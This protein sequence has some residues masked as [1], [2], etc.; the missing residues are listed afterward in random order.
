[1][2]AS[3]AG[4][5]SAL[6]HRY[7]EQ[8]ALASTATDGDD[9]K[10]ESDRQTD[11]EDDGLTPARR[12]VKRKAQR[13]YFAAEK[14]NQN[15]KL[16]HSQCLALPDDQWLQ[17]VRLVQPLIAGILAP[18]A[19]NWIHWLQVVRT[20]TRT[21]GAN[22]PSVYVCRNDGNSGCFATYDADRERW[23]SATLLHSI[24]LWNAPGVL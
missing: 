18:S 9:E 15:G 16:S 1:M 10:D 3:A 6:A 24:V 21:Y 17:R 5:S 8:T 2:A 22:Q 23:L 20:T 12:R 13:A 14:G 7:A 11:E 19:E 4:P